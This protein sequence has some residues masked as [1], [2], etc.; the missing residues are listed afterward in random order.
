MG[1]QAKKKQEKENIASTWDAT[2]VKQQ[3]HQPLSQSTSQTRQQ[4]F[5]LN[6]IYHSTTIVFFFFYSSALWHLVFCLIFSPLN[7]S[8]FC[9]FRFYGQCLPTFFVFLF[10][11][12]VF[13]RLYID[14]LTEPRPKTDKNPK[15]L[16]TKTLVICKS[17]DCRN[18][19]AWHWC[20]IQF[21]FGFLC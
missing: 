20:C 8:S 14:W 2:K 13:I 15:H 4:L 21:H 3:K 7:S 17:A 1:H 16:H 10:F 11:F 6:L 5:G 19:V 9:S 12:L 18:N